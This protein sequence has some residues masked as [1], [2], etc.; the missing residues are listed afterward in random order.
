MNLD[1]LRNGVG[2][3]R[4]E[5]VFDRIKFFTPPDGDYYTVR[6]IPNSLFV[7]VGLKYYD[8]NKDLFKVYAGRKDLYDLICKMAFEATQMMHFP[9]QIEEWNDPIANN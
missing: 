4:T 7:V 2:F 5:D 9:L 8:K 1:N 3:I 6:R